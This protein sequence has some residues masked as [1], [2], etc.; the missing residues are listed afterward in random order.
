MRRDG[1]NIRRKSEGDPYPPYTPVVGPDWTRSVP[2]IE[3]D[4]L[5][6]L[7]SEMVIESGKLVLEKRGCDENFAKRN[8]M[9]N[10]GWFYTVG[11][12]EAMK[13]VKGPLDREYIRTLD[14]VP[15]EHTMNRVAAEFQR[16]Y[17]EETSAWL[18]VDYHQSIV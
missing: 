5:K 1:K 18:G 16:V 12:V 2:P 7:P 8:I 3:P 4:M 15:D 10:A 13:E 14:V 11:H 17:G 6:D 9:T